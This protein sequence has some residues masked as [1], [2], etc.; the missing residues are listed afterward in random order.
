MNN[1]LAE[2]LKAVIDAGGVVAAQALIELLTIGLEE[3]IVS[4]ASK[5]NPGR[6]EDLMIQWARELGVVSQ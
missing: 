4:V 5:D 2:L 3:S 1:T 6:H